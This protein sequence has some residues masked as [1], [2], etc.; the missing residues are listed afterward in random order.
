MAAHRPPASRPSTHESRAAIFRDAVAILE[1]EFPYPLTVE[2][3][4]RRVASSPRQLQRAFAEV[5]GVGF[6]TLL[7]RIRMARAAELLVSTEVPVKSIGQFVGYQQPSQ[8]AK[9]FKRIYGASPSE[10]RV[11]RVARPHPEEE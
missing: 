9:A 11:A 4:A 1:R 6:R 2:E 3:I 7:A 10:Y 5:G 8:F